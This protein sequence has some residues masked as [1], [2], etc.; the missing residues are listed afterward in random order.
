MGSL[1]VISAMPARANAID[2]GSEYELRAGD[3]ILA[4]NR[5][6]TSH[7]LLLLRGSNYGKDYELANR[8]SCGQGEN[9]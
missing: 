1:L 4:R 2:V 9:A 7:T 5:L 3:E 6:I 8:I